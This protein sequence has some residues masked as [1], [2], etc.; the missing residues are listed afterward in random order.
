MRSARS[1][2]KLALTLSRRLFSRNL[3]RSGL[4]MRISSVSDGKASLLPLFRIFVIRSLQYYLV[5]FG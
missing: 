4:T 1:V 2:S 5:S 3:F